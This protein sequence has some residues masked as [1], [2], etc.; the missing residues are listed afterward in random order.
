MTFLKYLI[1]LFLNNT[2]AIFDNRF[3]LNI[4]ICISKKNF[5]FII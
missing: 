5:W 2:L 1:F 4:E 3:M